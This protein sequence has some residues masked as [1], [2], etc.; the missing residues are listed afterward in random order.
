MICY[1]AVAVCALRSKTRES[2]ILRWI[3]FS[4]IAAIAVDEFRQVCRVLIKYSCSC[5][6]T[7]LLSLKN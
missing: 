6:L 1:I 3:T 5:Y 4:L 7:A 2:S